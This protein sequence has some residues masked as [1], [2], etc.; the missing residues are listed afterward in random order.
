MI[1]NIINILDD[2]ESIAKTAGRNNKT[3]SGG[4]FYASK[5]SELHAKSVVAYQKLDVQLQKNED[6]SI[7]NALGKVKNGIDIF[8][9]QKA[10]S[11]PKAKLRKK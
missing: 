11:R 1:N 8:L 2:A 6:V 5:F 7:K 10:P 3:I 9:T 4:G